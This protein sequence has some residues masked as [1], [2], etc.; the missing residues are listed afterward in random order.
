MPR[1]F[2]TEYVNHCLRF[3]TRYTN[4]IFTSDIDKQN[5][6]VCHEALK[7]LSNENKEIIFS[8]YRDRDTIP[9]NVYRV[10][11]EKGIKRDDIWQMM[12]SLEYDIAKRR[13][14]I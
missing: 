9:N 12:I 2:Y 1:T 6:L 14:L 3:Y 11:K 8:I 5:W 10:S 7:T 4:P 13:G